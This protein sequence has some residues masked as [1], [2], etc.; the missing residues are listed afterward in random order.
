MNCALYGLSLSR[1]WGLKPGA[2]KLQLHCSFI[3]DPPLRRCSL[4]CIVVHYGT[5][6]AFASVSKAIAVAFYFIHMLLRK[7]ASFSVEGLQHN[8]R[9]HPFIS[10][11]TV[12]GFESNPTRPFSRRKAINFKPLVAAKRRHDV[13][14]CPTYQI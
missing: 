8:W 12:S 9:R 5:V 13:A 4:R 14:I 3:V 2:L 7:Y 10:L 1:F 11:P 6:E